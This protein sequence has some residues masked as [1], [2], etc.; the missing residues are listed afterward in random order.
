MKSP[1]FTLV[2]V[3]IVVAIIAII[4]AIALPSYNDSIR[5][6]RRADA[7]AAME[8]FANTAEQIYTE[9]SSYDGTDL[10]TEGK[11]EGVGDS[12]Y[13]TY[14]VA[15]AAGSFTITATPQASQDQDPCGTMTLDHR[16]DKTHTG[17]QADCW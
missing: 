3:M 17:T 4:V 14:T 13:Y 7:Q 16:G 5:K 2:E 12:D 15:D 8:R 1:G 9:D 11:P 10:T 6:A